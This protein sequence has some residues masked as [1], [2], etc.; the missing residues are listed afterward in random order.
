MYTDGSSSET[1]TDSATVTNKAFF[2]EAFYKLETAR[3]NLEHLA[4]ELR[5]D[6]TSLIRATRLIEVMQDINN[7]VVQLIQ[8]QELVTSAYLDYPKST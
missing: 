4:A 7:M 1:R 3:A 5:Y 8:L 6:E 2:A